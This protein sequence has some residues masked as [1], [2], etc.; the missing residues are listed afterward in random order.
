M[1]AND[2]YQ[3]ALTLMFGSGSD[4]DD[5]RPYF[6]PTLN[7]LLAENFELNN[8]IRISKGMQPLERIPNLQ[9]MDDDVEYEDIF[10]AVVLPY[11]CAG[12]M[13]L[14]DDRGIGSEY[15]NKYEYE[16]NR[17]ITGYWRSVQ[18]VYY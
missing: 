15:K 1:T 17:L 4:A 11:G 7:I 18:D 3:S 9:S 6:L 5:Y 16:R 2:I 10:C 13:Y 8:G 14:E 12:S